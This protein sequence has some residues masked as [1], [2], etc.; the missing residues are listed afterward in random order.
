MSSR[1]STTGGDARH[2]YE[3]GER[4]PV[5]EAVV[6]AL[7]E[8]GVEYEDQPSAMA[9]HFDPEALDRL[10]DDARGSRSG[11]GIDDVGLTLWGRRLRITGDAVVVE[12]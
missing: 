10:V 6:S 1:G 9:D 11:S 2:R 4:E 7:C 3:V 8:V 5:T 12:E